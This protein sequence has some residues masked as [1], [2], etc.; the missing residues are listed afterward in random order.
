M[1][2]KNLSIIFILFLSVT[3]ISAL[4]VFLTEEKKQPVLSAR[5]LA[6]KEKIEP[7][8]NAPSEEARASST[9]SKKI[10]KPA[11]SA[12]PGK[13]EEIIR[14]EIINQPAL[15]TEEKIKA[16][17]IIDGVKFEAEIKT[18]A[19]VY[20]LMNL[21]KAENKIIFFGKDYS[22]LGFFVEEINGLRN[23]QS[24]KN[25]VYYVNGRPA[26]VGVSNYMIKTG[27]IIEW[28]YEEKSF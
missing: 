11:K 5:P 9:P 7:A 24:G 19:S 28:K 15:I 12:P 25:W 20:D 6:I 27:D 14:P 2:T 13:A 18:G 26:Q 23:N 22:E 4:T 21:L 1:K 10:V 17:M 16:V 3:L 8:V